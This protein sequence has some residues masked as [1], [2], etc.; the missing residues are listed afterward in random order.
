MTWIEEKEEAALEI[1]GLLYENRMIRTFY[2][3]K[4]EGW[5]L[6]SGLYS[7]LY[8]QL[9]PLVSYPSVFEKVCKAMVRMTREE[10]PEITRVIGIA[11]AGVPIAAGMS[12]AGGIPGGFTRKMDN[13]KSLAQFR[14]AVTSY[15]EH[16]ML[17]GELASGDNVALVDDLV[18]R[19]DSKLLALEQVKY[20][21]QKRGLRSVECRTVLVVLD[22]EQGG[23]EA[24]EKE[25]VKLLSLIP[26]K[27][28]G[29]P[30]LKDVMAKTEWETISHYL[31]E[32]THFQQK[33]VQERLAGLAGRG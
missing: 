28:V 30:L 7:P 18:T 31:E 13:V 8:I 3:D 22:R 15:G 11:M 32:P 4:P 26:F 2:R 23:R 14:E 12:V 24:A 27:T 9:R 10:A 17:E 6:V 25:Q 19:F 5:T 1:L 16:A 21:I 29:L 20:E 33:Y